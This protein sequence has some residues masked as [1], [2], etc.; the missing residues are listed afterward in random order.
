MK[1]DLFIDGGFLDYVIK[2]VN[3]GKHPSAFNY[4]MFADEICKL[5]GYTRNRTYYYHCYPFEHRNPTEEQKEFVRKRRIFLN[6]LQRT[7]RFIFKPGRVNAVTNFCQKCHEKIICRKCGNELLLRQKSADTQLAVDAVILALKKQTEAIVLIGGD[8][9]FITTFQEAR[10][11]IQT[12]LAFYDYKTHGGNVKYSDE[13]FNVF[14]ERRE[15][16]PS[17]VQKFIINNH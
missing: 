11:H 8:A 10:N 12:G 5:F 3:N 14:D 16:T 9:D 13:L 1:A 6:S 15:M 17:F 4:E 7:P 2:A